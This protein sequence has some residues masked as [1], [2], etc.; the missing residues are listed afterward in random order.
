MIQERSIE[1]LV[2]NICNDFIVDSEMKGSVLHGVMGGEDTSYSA[3][4]INGNMVVLMESPTGALTLFL[5]D[6]FHNPVSVAIKKESW[7]DTFKEFAYT[8]ETE[9]FLKAY[10]AHMSLPEDIRANTETAKRIQA[11]TGE[12]KEESPDWVKDMLDN[13]TIQ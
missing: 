3:G 5:Y 9:R 13:K 2:R 12:T 8:L 11:L 4:F 7:V 10:K 6:K 1:N